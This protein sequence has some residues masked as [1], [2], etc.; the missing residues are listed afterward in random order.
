MKLETVQAW[1]HHARIQNTKLIF[2]AALAAFFLLRL[3]LLPPLISANA[4]GEAL[5]RARAEVDQRQATLQAAL[6]AAAPLRGE[7]GDFERRGVALR[8]LPPGERGNEARRLAGDARLLEH[9]AREAQRYREALVGY[10]EALMARTRDLG[11]RGEALRPATWPIVEHTRLYPPPIGQNSD[12]HPPAADQ[13]ASWAA[14]I[15]SGAQ[16]RIDEA[17]AAATALGRST[18]FLYRLIEIDQQYHEVL[19][20]YAVQLDQQLAQERPLSTRQRSLAALTTIVLG[21]LLA[22]ALALLTGRREGRDGILTQPEALLAAAGAAA[23]YYLTPGVLP[24]VLG[25]V[26]LLLIFA[27]WPA[28]ALALIP[29]A[30]PFYYRPRRIGDLSFTL[31]ETFILLAFT[32]L[33]AR[34]ALGKSSLPRLRRWLREPLAWG[35]A[36]ILLAALISLT[37]PLLVDQRVALRELRRTIIEPLLFLTLL[38]AIDTRERRFAISGFIVAASFVASD[39][40]VQLVLGRGIWAMEGVPR[41]IGLLPS[42]TALGIVLGAALAGALA[43]AWH[44]DSSEARLGYALLAA[45]LGLATALTFT[46]GAWLGVAAALLAILALQR[47]W[48]RLL[49]AG[50]ILAVGLGA[51]SLINAERFRTMFSLSQG[52]GAARLEIWASTLRLLQASPLTGAGLDQ[53]VHQDPQRFAIPQIRLL[54]IAHPH[55]IILDLWVQL[56]L[57]GMLAALGVAGLALWQLGR[58]AQKRGR[59]DPQRGAWALAA[60]AILI[61]IFVHGMFDQA[62]LGA[63][64]ILLFWACVAQALPAKAG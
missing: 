17:V 52:T 18:F 36:L 27:R 58:L 14:A 32:A 44:P 5:D 34:I 23:I 50:G 30:I 15:E 28:T 19:N 35:A 37:S 49:L 21:L 43:R 38:A 29:A 9:L 42:S 40:L 47:A 55:N 24:A 46:R 54:A 22:T 56:G 1:R 31:A 33:A 6:Q 39:A 2:V 11:P 4:P 51:L 57:L 53:F 12:F 8:W 60:A 64:M 26:L 48:S 59:G 3:D 16:G 7:R 13:I 41:L 62:L 10:D 63:D 25:A 45:P 20:R 61:D